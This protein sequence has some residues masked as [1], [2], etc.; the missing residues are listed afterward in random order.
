MFSDGE[1]GT[2][3]DGGEIAPGPSRPGFADAGRGAAMLGIGGPQEPSAPM[4]FP[5]TR[6]GR[7]ESI[8]REDTAAM[9][10]NA[11]PDTPFG[12]EHVRRR[13]TRFSGGPGGTLL[14]RA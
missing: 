13:R 3:G 14:G 6:I 4:S 1:E 8:L 12:E 5:D 10:A 7:R 11:G 9:R 2:L